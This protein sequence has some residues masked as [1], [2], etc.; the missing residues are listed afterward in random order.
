MLDYSDSQSVW[1]GTIPEVCENVFNVILEK[2]KVFLCRNIR[3]YYAIAVQR[4]EIMDGKT[5]VC[6]ISGHGHQLSI[7]TIRN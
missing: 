4:E 3:V 6:V 1:R 5:C 2:K 7:P